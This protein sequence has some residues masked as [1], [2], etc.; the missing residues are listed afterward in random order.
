MKRPVIYIIAAALILVL[1]LL[2]AV[3]PMVG[4]QRLIG[5]AG[6]RQGGNFPQSSFR[7][8]NSQNGTP[9]TQS[10]NPQNGITPNGQGNGTTNNGTNSQFQPG[11]GF[12]GRGNGLLQ[13]TRIL[14]YV[15]YAGELILGLLAIVGL[16]L[17]KKWGVI[18]A[19][20]TSAVVLIATIPGMFRM[21]SSIVLIENLLKVIL[22][23]GIIVLV[24][25]P[26]PKPVEA[27][28]Q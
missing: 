27:P 6:F 15:L 2:S 22:A 14:Q 13:V 7:S 26:R 5:G 8:R 16:W 28:N 18:L 3:L 19:I 12:S 4:G 9:P 17:S 10:N 1:I 25:L 23:I 11:N 20:I 24:V 21:F